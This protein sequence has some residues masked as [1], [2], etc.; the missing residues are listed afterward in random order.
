LDLLR[1][2]QPTAIG[3]TAGV[4]ALSS[5]PS[6]RTDLSVTLTPPEGSLSIAGGVVQQPLGFDGKL[7]IEAL[8][9]PKLLAPIDQPA[10]ALLA[11][12]STPI[13]ASPSGR[14]RA[15]ARRR[16]HQRLDRP[17]GHRRRG[18]GACR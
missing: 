18:A 1:E 15:R 12:C 9:L 3:L 16:P 13:S 11:A 8:S 4:K 7:R 14:R 6:A 2:G 17:R 10:A 5:D